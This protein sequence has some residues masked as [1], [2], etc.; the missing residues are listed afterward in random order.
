MANYWKKKLDELNQSNGNSTSKSTTK[1]ATSATKS[2]YWKNKLTELEKAEDIA[3]VKTTTAEF[4]NYFGTDRKAAREYAK[5]NKGSDA[6]YMASNGDIVRLYTDTK[7]SPLESRFGV[8][9]GDGLAF[10]VVRENEDSAEDNR[11]WFQA[12]AFDD[13]YDFGDVTKTILGTAGDATLGV[14]KG[15]LGAAEGIADLIGYGVA[16]AADWLGFDGYAAD[17]RERTEK[18]LYGDFIDNVRDDIGVNDYSVLGDKADMIPEAIGQIGLMW[19]TAGVGA[20]AGLGSVGTAAVSTGTM[21][22][23]SMG[24]GMSEAYQNGATDNEA[25]SYG[26]TVGVIDAISERLFAGLGKSVGNVMGKPISSLDDQVA[27]KI[28]DSITKKFGTGKSAHAFKTLAEGAT[29]SMFEGGEEL[30]AG[31][32]SAFAK[33]LTYMSDE[34]VGELLEDESLLEQFIVSTLASGIMQGGDVKT[35]I[36]TDT[37]LVTGLNYDEQAVVDK[38]IEKRIAEAEKKGDLTAKDKTK[39]RD[40]VMEDLADGGISIDDIEA[41]LGGDAYTQWKDSADKHDALQ[42][43]YDAIKNEYDELYNMKSGDKSDA[44]ADHQAELKKRLEEMKAQL[45]DTTE[46]DTLRKHLNDQVFGKVSNSRLVEA[47]NESGRRKQPFSVDL[48]QYDGKTKEI[49]QGIMDKGI[50]NNSNK[51][52]K[53][54]EYAAK[55]AA[56][57]GFDITATTTE[58]IIAMETEKRGAEWVEQHLKGKTP[59]AYKMPDGSIAINV[60]S[61]EGRRFLLGHEITHTMEGAG[62]YGTLKDLLFAYE[63]NKTSDE[64]FE[65]RLKEIAEKYDG[66]NEDAEGELL[67][68]LV[69]EYLYSD[70]QFIEH[71]SAQNRNLFQ[72]IWDEI[73][74]LYNMATAGSQEARD[75]ERIKRE[76]EKAYRAETKNTAKDGGVKY[77]IG[78]DANGNKFVDVTEDIFDAND[79]ESVARTIQKVIAKK[80]NNRIKANGQTFQINK[81]TND[82]FRRSESATELLE[83]APQVY[84]DKLKTIANADEILATAK[85]WIGEKTKHNRK[86]DIVEFG[87]GNVMYRVNGNGYIADV[88]VGIRKN[89]SAVLYDLVNIYETKIAEGPVTVASNNNSQRR[90]GTSAGDIIAENSEKSSENS[91]IRYSLTEYT[92]D[93]KKAHNDAAIDY[94]GKTYSWNETGYLLLNGTRLDFS[95]KHEGASGGYRTVDHR[96]ISNALGDDYGGDSYSGAL[97]QFMS[98]GNIRIIP[99]MGGINL[100]VMPTEAQEKALAGYIQLHRGEVVLD[101]D[102]ANGY[103]VASVE[104]PIGTRSGKVLGDIRA[105]F[106]DG[107]KPEMSNAYSLTKEGEHHRYARGDG[108]MSEL[109]YAPVKETVQDI[110]PV[111]ETA[112]DAPIVEEA[113]PTQVYDRNTPIQTVEERTAAKLQNT[114][115]ELAKNNQLRQDSWVSFDEEIASLQAEYESKKNKDTKVANTILRRIERLRTMQSNVDADYAKRISDLAERVNKMNSPVYKRAEQ[116]KSKQEE[117]TTEMENLVGDTSTW[118]DKKLGLSYKTNTLRRNLRDVVRDANGNRDIQKADAIY[119]ELQGKYA[120][121]EAALNKEATRIKQPYAEM[122]ITKAEDA[123]IQML[124]ELRHNPDTTLTEEAVT[125]Y[126]NKHKNNIDKA[127]VDKAI[128]DARET[129][130]SLL[131]RVNEVL[132]EQ[133]MKEIPYRQG[134]FPHFTDPKQGFLAKL[135]NWKT[136]DFEIPTDIAGLTEQFNPNRSWQSFNKERKS[137]TTDYSFTKG[138]DTYVQGALDWIYHI[139]DIQKRRAFENHIRY[140]HSDEGIKERINNIRKNEEYDADEMQE[141]I[142]LVYKEAGNPLNNFVTDL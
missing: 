48:S 102:D 15:F 112:A 105:Y 36:K 138:M 50:V 71:L 132:K 44:Q 118:V 28:G 29:K 76:F 75:L 10:E 137:D 45:G 78:V 83:S 41:T 8:T 63:K 96:D 5:A 42:S 65:A 21:F 121:N 89:G 88:L 98:E 64:A 79:G 135:F 22:T 55:V 2:D 91:D 109:A 126:Y 35:A 4:S 24:N 127:K 100:S 26:L 123:Y 16:G 110:A 122:K 32:G 93:E 31:I 101:I 40:E 18:N 74:Y 39:I 13:G 67:A 134:Y 23:S 43:E 9:I 80:F 133:G 51:A 62:N 142:D 136:K 68:D 94:F 66:I 116:R 119:D 33:K 140:I 19:A 25:F 70:S 77:H 59:N 130:D 34:E 141:Q 128:A 95:G 7:K 106:E 3:P 11:K 99:E 14:G 139:E 47:Y 46:R 52:H 108:A 81:T 58:E 72:K 49:L 82:E 53:F 129:Y 92:A 17:V 124:G 84:N 37:D 85:N 20:A 57:K 97:V 87:R 6:H 103:T 86:D 27:K 69:G 125:D 54:W 30:V 120:H 131:I 1:E 113:T 56:D 107:T 104:Y 61:L 60:K 115:A 90:Q 38:V 114:E 117:Y 12:P 111:K 73:K